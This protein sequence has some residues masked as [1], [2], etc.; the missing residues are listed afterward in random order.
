MPRDY[1]IVLNLEAPITKANK[2]VPGK[3]N[4]KTETCYLGETFG[5]PHRHRAGGA[6]RDRRG[7]HYWTEPRAGQHQ[8]GLLVRD[9]RHGAGKFH[10]KFSRD[11]I[12]SSRRPIQLKQFGPPRKSAGNTGRLASRPIHAC[13]A[14][15]RPEDGQ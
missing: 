5:P 12:E 8:S 3:I 2:G 4:L 14:R 11:A 1:D 10:L 6:D 15:K 7:A 13:H 9:H